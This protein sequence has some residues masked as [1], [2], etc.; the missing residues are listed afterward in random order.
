MRSCAIVCD[1]VRS[2]ERLGFIAA[3]ENEAIALVDRHGAAIL[4]LV[5]ALYAAGKF[6][7]DQILDVPR[8][9]PEGRR[10][11]DGSEAD[12]TPATGAT[13]ADNVIVFD[14]SCADGTTRRASCQFIENGLFRRASPAP[15][16]GPEIV[17]AD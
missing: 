1:P 15:R 8:Q 9:T 2:D 10:L 4:S 11:V 17:A 5:D 16:Q 7:H 12:S 13:G 6:D 3:F 14:I